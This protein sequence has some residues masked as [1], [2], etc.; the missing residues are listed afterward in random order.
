MS[1]L[2]HIGTHWHPL[3]RLN[4]L[5]T[6]VFFLFQVA[7]VITVLVVPGTIES[8]LAN[9][10]LAVAWGWW[11]AIVFCIFWVIINAL[12]LTITTFMNRRRPP[13]TRRNLALA[14]GAPL[15]FVVMMITWSPAIRAVTDFRINRDFENSRAEFLAICERILAEGEGASSI[16]DNQAIG[17]F[18][19]VDV[20]YREKTVYFELGD[21]VRAYGYAC[22]AGNT[23]LPAED[24]RYE[25]EKL[26]ARFYRFTEIENRLTPE[27]EA[28]TTPAIP[29]ASSSSQE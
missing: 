1:I 19:R 20:L 27:P 28:T 21:D 17:V 24:D 15:A 12:W 22:V 3:A 25:Y 5:I 18:K 11:C 6:L 7:A 16:Q 4:F 9:V 29:S 13:G 26:D 14:W 8:G 23:R 10:L 2:I